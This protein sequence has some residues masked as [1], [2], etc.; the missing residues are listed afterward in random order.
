MPVM[1][2][3]KALDIIRA[4]YPDLPVIIITG[5]DDVNT[6]VECMKKGAYDFVTKPFD[7]EPFLLTVA[8]AR[9]KRNLD[10]R[11]RLLQEENERNL[12]DLNLEKS[13]LKTIIN[14]IPTGIMVTNY[15][16]ELVLY[17]AAL[18]QML[19]VS[20]EI[21]APIY[22]AEIINDD[23]LIERLKRILDDKSQNKE[24]I[25]YELH[26]GENVLK[27]ISAPIPGPGR[28]LSSNIAGTVTVIEDI[29]AFKQLDRMKSDFVNMV[30]HELRSPLAAIRQMNSVLPEVMPCPLGERQQDYDDRGIKKI[31]ALLALINN[32]LD[33][34]K[35][36]EFKDV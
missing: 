4:K 8:R 21:S 30:A 36:K 34:A 35:I 20:R 13:R 14:C 12:Y 19:D 31:D 7:M 15:N 1:G 5:Y 22:I 9:E 16:L 3:E 32:L 33:V 2:G 25:V 17:N 6:A 10:Q 27:S 11:T 26:K 29:T 23:S 28:K 24:S 18:M